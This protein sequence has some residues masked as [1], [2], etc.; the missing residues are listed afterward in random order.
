MARK[1][2][3]LREFLKHQHEAREYDEFLRGKVAVAR[4]QINVGDYSNADEVEARVATRRADFL[5]KA[6]QAGS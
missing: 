5:V 4:A 1:P 2:Q 3:I 6:G